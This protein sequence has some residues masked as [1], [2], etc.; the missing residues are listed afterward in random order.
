MAE[1]GRFGDTHKRLLA[2]FFTSPHLKEDPVLA[3][4]T[5][6]DDIGVKGMSSSKISVRMECERLIASSIDAMGNVLDVSGIDPLSKSL[7]KEQTD[8]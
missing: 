8:E 6:C 7:C 3:F 2:T 5:A 4:E 1:E